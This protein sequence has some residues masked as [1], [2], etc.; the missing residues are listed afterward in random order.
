MRWLIDLS[1]WAFHKGGST[2]M[3]GLQPRFF[4]KDGD[5]DDND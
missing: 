1:G 3:S 4:Q 2:L 5:G